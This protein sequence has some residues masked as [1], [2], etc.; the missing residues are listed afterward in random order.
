MIHQHNSQQVRRG[1]LYTLLG[2]IFFSCMAAAIYAAEIRGS[3]TSVLLSSFMR[4][5]VNLILI[6]LPYLLMRRGSE[7][8]GD[9]SLSLFLRGFFGSLAMIAYFIAIKDIG[10]GDSAFIR[11]SSAIFV[12]ALSPFILQEKGSLKGW[13]AILCSFVGLYFVIQPRF[14]DPNPFGRIIALSSGL[15]TA[16]AWMMVAHSGRR[17]KPATMIFYLCFIG[18]LI[19]LSIFPFIDLHLSSD[20]YYWGLL[21][22]SG[23][24][25]TAGQVLC[26]RGYQLAPAHLN[27]AVEYAGPV[28]SM[29]LGAL[30]FS[31]FPDSKGLIGSAIIFCCGVVLPFWHHSPTTHLEES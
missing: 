1:L 9:M 22:L 14:D 12:A 21:V 7:L 25:A 10:I 4:L 2:T 18:C 3:Q 31:H 11:S 30:L 8:L 23:L 26:T 15:F 17:N 27:A 29:V 16:L 13:T 5:A 28:A 20:Y 24:L 19:H 6:S